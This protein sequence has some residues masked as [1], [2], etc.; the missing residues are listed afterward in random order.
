[1][2]WYVYLITIPAAAF[3]AQVATELVGR[4]V[5]T[6]FRLRRKALERMRS[7]RNISL[8]IPREL[9]IS[10]RQIREYDQAVRNL[11]A[12]Q[13]TF[14]D[15]G[16]QLLA[17]GES[18][19]TVRIL[20]ALFGLDMDRAG[21]ELI[22]LSEAYATATG[23]SDEFRHAIERAFRATRAALAA[24]HRP[25][26]DALIKIRPEP[27]N[28][29]KAAHLRPRNRP[30]HPRMVSPQAIPRAKVSPRAPANAKADRFRFLDAR[31]DLSG[32]KG[33]RNREGAFFR[34]RR[35]ETAPLWNR[36]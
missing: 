3:L 12:A 29:P 16:A 2:Q 7:F 30:R 36:F 4:P 35:P 25:S 9:A 32:N 17:F 24:S 15:L 14:S 11:R 5:R 21:H 1:M 18:E 26:R 31:A 22:N 33:L 34:P 23:D 27:M 6:V 28:L 8:P 10:S 13:R 20:V 19:P